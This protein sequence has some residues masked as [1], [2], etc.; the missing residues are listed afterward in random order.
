[1]TSPSDRAEGFKDLPD[2]VTYIRQHPEMFRHL[3]KDGVAAASLLVDAAMRRG[4]QSI[5]IEVADSWYAVGSDADW[6]AGIEVD[7]FVTIVP[8]PVLGANAINPTVL[9]TAYAE[10]VFTVSRGET[11]QVLGAM[12]DLTAFRVDFTGCGRIVIFR[13]NLQ[14]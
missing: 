13:M 10:A 12:P 3:V 4:A 14:E 6:L 7:P 11:R 8:M 2:A 1:M 9:L 5:R